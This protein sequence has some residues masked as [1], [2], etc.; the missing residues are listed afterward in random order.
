[1]ADRPPALLHPDKR[2]RCPKGT[3][4]NRKGECVPSKPRNN[5]T[6]KVVCPEGQEL[7]RGNCVDKCG[8]LQKRDKDGNC[9]DKTGWRAT[10]QRVKELVC[11]EGEEKYKGKCVKKCPDHQKRSSDGSCVDRKHPKRVRNKT[12]RRG[13]PRVS[14]RGSPQA[15][16]A[17]SSSQKPRS[18][19]VKLVCPENQVKYKGNCVEK[20]K[21]NEKRN[22]AGDCVDKKWRKERPKPKPKSPKRPKKRIVSEDDEDGEELMDTED[23]EEDEEEDEDDDEDLSFVA[24]EDDFGYLDEGEHPDEEKDFEA[25]KEEYHKILE[26]IGKGQLRGI[27]GPGA[28]P[29]KEGS[30]SS[31]VDCKQCLKKHTIAEMEREIAARRRPKA[32][33]SS[34]SPKARAAS[35]KVRV[36]SSSPKPTKP[37]SPK[38]RAA[39]P[40]RAAVGFAPNQPMFNGMP[41]NMIAVR[42]KNPAAP[43]PAAAKTRARRRHGAR[44]RSRRRR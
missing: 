43:A 5:A 30:S 6:A 20:C 23:E 34:S 29:L 2:E 36:S 42:R 35:P 22:R 37:P 21:E 12:T 13:T 8:P 31:A 4:R 11:P 32:R 16:K 9:V 33:V 28:P 40:P 39:S 10:A 26:R 17:A 3:H 7:F 14:P 18:R 1:M 41:V 19:K 25:M 44:H 24:S 27:L 15:P 38:A